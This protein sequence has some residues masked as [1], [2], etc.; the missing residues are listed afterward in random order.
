ML[1][2]LPHLSDLKNLRVPTPRRPPQDMCAPRNACLVASLGGGLA[3]IPNHDDFL[4]E[5]MRPQF[6]GFD[7][8]NELRGFMKAAGLSST[9]P[10]LLYLW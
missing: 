1:N 2:G 6:G 5:D 9:S 10:D 8:N 3:R 7:G 4:K